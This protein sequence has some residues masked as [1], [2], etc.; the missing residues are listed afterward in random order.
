VIRPVAGNLPLT[1]NPRLAKLPTEP[2]SPPEPASGP[3]PRPFP[4][5]FGFLFLNR[6]LLDS[7]KVPVLADSPMLT[8]CPNCATS[9][10]VE[11]ASLRLPRGWARQVR[12]PRC[13]CVWQA[14][15][16]AS[17]KLVLAADSVAPVRR[18][19]AAA[20]A[21]VG[22]TTSS[23]ALRRARR[24]A[25][26]GIGAARTRVRAVWI[27]RPNTAASTAAAP[28]AHGGLGFS[29][30]S[31]LVRYRAAI[32]RYGDARSG[33]RLSL[34]RVQLLILGLL[35]ADATIISLRA[36]LIWLMPQTASFYSAVGLPMDP[37]G[38][39]FDDVSAVAERHDANP[40]LVVNG[41]IKNGR[42][43]SEA[44]PNLR[45]VIRDAGHQEIYSWSAA[46]AH[47]KLAPR[48]A[49]QFRSE[50]AWPPADTRDV[51]VRFDRDGGL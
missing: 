2:Q 44:V 27:G 37:Y 5:Q 22:N 34:S 12:C 47:E 1:A 24:L 17:D 35:V 50:L 42:A 11:M 21:L 10:G 28:A 26:D 43:R 33:R 6:P 45:F 29:I 25:A 31:L 15:L 16:S 46:P 13:R 4:G 14:D 48:E 41:K 8:V 39:R 40:V 38:L 19:M 30:S 51:V 36:E 7:H 23:P 49:I 18:A 20:Q 9:Y 3:F 32:R